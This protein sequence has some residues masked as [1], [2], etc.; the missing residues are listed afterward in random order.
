MSNPSSNNNISEIIQYTSLFSGDTSSPDP[1][2]L[3]KAKNPA[4]SKS[5]SYSVTLFANVSSSLKSYM[6]CSSTFSVST[7][8]TFNNLTFSTSNKAISAS[9]VITL[10]LGAKNPV[11]SSTYLR[12]DPGGLSLAYAFNLYN[13]GTRPNQITTNDGTVQLGNLTASTTTAPAYLVLNNFTLV[14]PSYS[15]KAVSLTFT[16]FNL[17]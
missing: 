9:N 10:R 6:T 11:S 8:N 7:P 14:N 2:V 3:Q 1:L 5:I 16:T 15:S 17:V 13:Q 12:I 4:S